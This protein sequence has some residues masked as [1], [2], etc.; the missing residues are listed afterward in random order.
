MMYS[1]WF[2]VFRQLYILL[3]FHEGIIANNKPQKL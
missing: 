1:F 2:P 3:A